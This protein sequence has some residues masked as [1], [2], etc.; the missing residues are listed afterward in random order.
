MPLIGI[1]H[2][3]FPIVGVKI[4]FERSRAREEDSDDEINWADADPGITQ[5]RDEGGSLCISRKY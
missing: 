2:V 3:S 4:T 1:S 5:W